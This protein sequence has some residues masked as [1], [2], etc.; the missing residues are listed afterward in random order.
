[1]LQILQDAAV[2][3]SEVVV[4]FYRLWECLFRG[5]RGRRGITVETRKLHLEVGELLAEKG[6]LLAAPSTALALFC[7][8]TA[9]L[10][11]LHFL[12]KFAHLFS[13]ASDV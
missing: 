2:E 1:M 10:H 3:F 13:E 5:L 6:V 11:P 4:R 8:V 9:G 12:L 7:I